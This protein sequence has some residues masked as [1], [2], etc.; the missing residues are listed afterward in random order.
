MSIWRKRAC[1]SGGPVLNLK[2]EVIG[3]IRG[4]YE[5]VDIKTIKKFLEKPDDPRQLRVAGSAVWWAS[6]AYAIFEVIK[7]IPGVLYDVIVD[8]IFGRGWLKG[9]VILILMGVL[10]GWGIIRFSKDRR[11]RRERKEKA[12][13]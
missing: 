2:G 12:S 1:G 10:V 11:T 6:A 9:V 13:K 5:A 7:V 8:P 3:V 4:A